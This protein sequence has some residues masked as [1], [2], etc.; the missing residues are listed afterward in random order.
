[1][2]ATHEKYE[3]AAGNVDGAVKAAEKIAEL[4]KVEIKTMEQSKELQTQQKK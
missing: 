1:M 2:L 4:D 3:G